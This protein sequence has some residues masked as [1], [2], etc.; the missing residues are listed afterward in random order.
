MKLY[1]LLYIAIIALVFASCSD[2]LNMPSFG[3]I[4]ADGTVEITF[5]VPDAQVIG[6]R[7]EAD[8]ESKI[9]N[10][11]AFVF[12]GNSDD[13]ILTQ[14]AET[15]TPSYLDNNRY[16]ASFK[17]KEGLKN[18]TDL[19]FIFIANLLGNNAIPEGITLQDLRVITSESVGESWNL[20]MCG[21]SNLSEL[22]SKDIS[23]TRNAA[24]VTVTDAAKENN[25]Y[26]PGNKSYPF[27]I[28]GTASESS[29][30]AAINPDP[31]LGI[32]SEAIRFPVEIEDD[33]NTPRYVHPTSNTEEG[34]AGNSF[35]IVKAPFN[36]SDY[37]YRLD[38]KKIS[39]DKSKEEFLD[40]ES[41]H[42]Y[43]VMI[44]EV[45]G[46]GYAT[47]EEAA[48][49][50]VQLIEYQIH[51]HAPAIFNMITDG[52]RELGV[53]HEVIYRNG[54]TTGESSKYIYVKLYSKQEEH[55]DININNIKEILDLHEVSWLSF[56]D[57]E[58][59]TNDKFAGALGTENDPNHKGK[60]F[61][62]PLLFKSEGEQ[63]NLETSV[64]VTW[65]GL[66]RE[67]PVIW[68]R[69]FKG[70]EL[71]S[72]RLI[73]RDENKQA[74][75]TSLQNISSGYTITNYWDFLDGKTTD[76]VLLYGISPEKN[77]GKIRNQGLHFPVMYGEKNKTSDGKT[78]SRWS[79]AYEVEFTSLENQEFSW[80][81]KVT[82]DNGALSNHVEVKT[83]L[84]WDSSVKYKTV[85]GNIVSGTHKSGDKLIITVTRPGNVYNNSGE[86][87]DE[88][89]D[90][91][92]S[93]GKLTLEV[94]PL[95][96]GNRTESKLAS[97]YSIDLYHTGFFHKDSQTHRKDNE[98][99][100]G[101][102][103]YYYEV[104]PIMGAHR[105]RYWLD[106]NLGAK[107]SGMYIESTGGVAFSG[108]KDAAGGYYEVAR[109]GDN[110]SGPK[111]FDNGSDRVS[112]PGYRVP[113]TKVW[114]AMRNSANFVTAVESSG[115]SSYYDTSVGRVYFPKVMVM[116]G[117][118]K[119]GESRSG[120]Y[121]TQDA[122]SGTEK[123]EIGRWLKL[124]MISGNSTSYV[125]GNINDGTTNP[126]YAASV[127]CI[128]DIDDPTDLYR[129]A[130]NVSGAT[131]VYL[132]TE[133]NGVR[134]PTTAWPGHAI[135]N[136]ATMLN[137]TFNFSLESPDFNP[138]DLY[139]IFNFI[140][141]EGIIHT[142]SKGKT[143]STTNITPAML[144]GWE[145]IGDDSE[146]LKDPNTLNIAGVPT[147]LG[148]HWRWDHN[149]DK[150]YC[151]KYDVG[152]SF[153]NGSTN[154][155]IYWKKEFNCPYIRLSGTDYSYRTGEYRGY[156]YYDIAGFSYNLSFCFAK[157]QNSSSSG[158]LYQADGPKDWEI[159][160][161]NFNKIENG[162]FYTVD[163]YNNSYPGVPDSWN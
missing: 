3:G 131:H 46:A 128:N 116:E 137:G 104:V 8:P 78:Q 61:R 65:K 58:E 138:E 113:K 5:S 73:I 18:S 89:N 13:A 94:T 152:P 33:K 27:Q 67:V 126:A 153:V 1:R 155:R 159:N 162:F 57:P 11:Y 112:P 4:D 75:N 19:S 93:V 60:V 70:S 133:K 154:Y 71:C 83:A 29:I 32:P 76:G 69:E 97:S 106:R 23:L 109:K 124:L 12:N 34:N 17:L 146:Y 85:N 121:W 28:Y 103:F 50:P 49:H 48:A 147:D 135:G 36:G 59:V 88:T 66:K 96:T 9:N 161:N 72:V 37:Y 44:L 80:E 38:F 64:T 105:M 101:N 54:N 148:Y 143:E 119:L 82:D 110:F 118:Q 26:T 151:S 87:E 108:D 7:A 98:A 77:N 21:K 107:S 114:D 53:T 134:T 158:D 45:T 14:I 102:N 140:D 125:N 139:V 30:T 20:I 39:E 144:E 117:N 149:D 157:A 150:V 42:W 91:T 156:Y 2:E 86:K 122:A 127:R 84:Y 55:E 74:K 10:I 51:D 130:F 123:E 129:T 41:N 47:P 142:M 35:I 111:M 145:V 100:D 68:T 25:N 132:Y 15:S 40:I 31:A 160:A 79:Y 56:G 22:F 81:L 141:S 16:S 24:K 90:Y 92:Y 62:I 43:Q 115:F 163:S 99:K 95:N 120:Y 136:H 63:G 6:T 52:I